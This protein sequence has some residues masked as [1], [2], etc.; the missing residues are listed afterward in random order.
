MKFLI[1]KTKLFW[2]TKFSFEAFWLNVDKLIVFCKY[3]NVYRRHSKGES[4]YFCARG[5]TTNFDNKYRIS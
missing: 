2:K 1:T 4:P 3:V 5:H